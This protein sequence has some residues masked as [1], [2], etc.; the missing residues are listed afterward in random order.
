MEEFEQRNMKA[1]QY[2]KDIKERYNYMHSEG[3]ID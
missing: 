3:I 2:N 1:I